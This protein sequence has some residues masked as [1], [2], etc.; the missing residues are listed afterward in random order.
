VQDV[1]LPEILH[2]YQQ[3][4]RTSISRSQ[5]AAQERGLGGL[6]SRLLRMVQDLSQARNFT[7]ISSSYDRLVQGGSVSVEHLLC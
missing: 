6:A 1:S 4:G 3:R 2:Q 5:A 7:V